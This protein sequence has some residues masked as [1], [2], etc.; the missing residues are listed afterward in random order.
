MNK[1]YFIKIIKKSKNSLPSIPTTVPRKL[2]VFSLCF[3]RKFNGVRCV[4][5]KVG[6]CFTTCS[7]IRDRVTSGNRPPTSCRA[8]LLR[9]LAMGRRYVFININT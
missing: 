9:T 4:K 1:K 6:V 5:L 3:K 2:E 8:F 7:R